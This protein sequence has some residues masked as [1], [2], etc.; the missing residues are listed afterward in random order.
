MKLIPL[1]VTQRT[2]SGTG[3]ARR[4]RRNGLIPAVLYGPGHNPL[5]VT[6]NEREFSGVVHGVQ[7]E[8]AIVDL[9]VADAPDLGGPAMLKE[10][11]HDPVR[12]HIV[13]ADLLRIDLTRT[14][15]TLVATRLE[16]RPAGVVDGGI[17]EHTTRE[18]EV[19]C[20]PTAIPDY[21]AADI[22]NL[23]IGHSVPVSVLV[24]PEGVELLTNPERVLA[25]ILVPRVVTVEVPEVAVAEGVE[26]EAAPAAEG[27]TPAA[28]PG[29]EEPKESKSR[30][31]KSKE[32]KS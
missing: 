14:I 4:D 13:H 7:G 23:N 20:L 2:A 30:E 12:G 10:V 27:E 9:Q 25:T 3:A 24:I 16:G 11:Q 31:S 22:T 29:A 19:S 1:L 32:T 8:H 26:G 6:V 17:L 18:V 28:K 15:T 21:L 5:H